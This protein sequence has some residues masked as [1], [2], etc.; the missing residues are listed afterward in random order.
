[1]CGMCGSDLVQSG[2]ERRKPATLVFC[3]LSGSTA[4][5]EHLD[6]EAVRE[7]QV[8]YFQEMRAAL[9][10]HGGTVEKFIGDAVVAAF[11][12]P[13]AH[14][15]DAVRALRAASEMRDRLAALNEGFERRF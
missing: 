1:M 15:D 9:E 5:G 7:L 8:A 6:A 13:V 12:I 10:R 3:A 14:E 2:P 4:L 11:G